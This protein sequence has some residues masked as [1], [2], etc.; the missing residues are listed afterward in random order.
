MVLCMII[1]HL[2]SANVLKTK[3]NS[4][5]SQLLIDNGI[6]KYWLKCKKKKKFDSFI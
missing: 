6:I 3:H 1:K 2:F 5:L 4:I